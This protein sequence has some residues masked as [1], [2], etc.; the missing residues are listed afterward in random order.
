[1]NDAILSLIIAT[2]G[3]LLGMLFRY[4]YYSKCDT[5][6]ILHCCKIHR[7]VVNETNNNNNNN[8]NNEISVNVVPRASQENAFSLGNVQPITPPQNRNNEQKAFRV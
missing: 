5:I 8:D 7:M 6:E 3:G 1:M 2:A 4:C